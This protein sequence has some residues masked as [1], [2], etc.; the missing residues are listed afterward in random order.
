VKRLKYGCE[1]RF[2]WLFLIIR[3]DRK[4]ERKVEIMKRDY[5]GRG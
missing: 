5:E 3:E 2:V 4:K 1:R